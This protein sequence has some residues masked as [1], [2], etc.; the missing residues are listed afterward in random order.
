M[1]A[2]KKKI[3]RPVKILIGL[4]LM[5]LGW[6]LV[7]LWINVWQPGLGADNWLIIS[8]AVIWTLFVAI[9]LSENLS[10]SEESQSDGSRLG[11]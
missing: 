9:V 1:K 4:F 11:G 2:K 7:G 8:L 3:S 5:A 10:A 6:V